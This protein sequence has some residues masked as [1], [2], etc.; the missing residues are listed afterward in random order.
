[1]SCRWLSQW[2]DTTADKCKLNLV[3]LPQAGG[4]T[5]LYNRWK[6]LLGDQVNVMPAKFPGRGTRLK[7]PAINAMERVVSQLALE[8]EKF[9]GAPFAILGSSMGGW[10]AYE[11]ALHLFKQSGLKPT[12][13]FVLASASPFAP[14]TLP[15][16]DGCTRE[17]MVDELISFNPEFAQIAQHDDLV[18]LLLPA[19][20][21]DFELCETYRPRVPWQIAS[22]IF[23]YAGTKDQVVEPHKVKGWTK[24]SSETVAV[25]EVEGGHFFIEHSPAK[26]LNQIKDH[27][28]NVVGQLHQPSSIE[29]A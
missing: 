16:L 7:E 8:I 14:R 1:M 3:C 26:V 6:A 25:D 17:E 4:D 20:I 19:I 10:I 12:A 23:A 29:L 15:F 28:A 24:L 13:L 27:A 21:G 5:S 2:F 11:L 18:D 22:P 9:G